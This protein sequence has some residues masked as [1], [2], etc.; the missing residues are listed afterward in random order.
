MNLYFIY[1]L[2][3]WKLETQEIKFKISE[4]LTPF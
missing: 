4:T 3:L 2:A 1:V